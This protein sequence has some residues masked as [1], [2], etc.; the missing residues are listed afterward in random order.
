MIGS[1]G[2]G[3]TQGAI[4]CMNGWVCVRCCA[5]LS[6]DESTDAKKCRCDS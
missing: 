5:E 1:G 6:V 3:E 4:S 2:C